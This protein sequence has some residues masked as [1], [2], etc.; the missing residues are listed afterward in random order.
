MKHLAIV[1]AGG[2]GSRM[3][4]SVPK[5]FLLLDGLPVLMHTLK[6]F[7]SSDLQPE[8]FLV[9]AANE[10]E[11]W[12]SLC[13]DHSFTIPHALITGG[14]NRFESVQN[15]LEHISMRST[16]SVPELLAGIH[17]GV[18]PLISNELISRLYAQ[19]AIQGTAIPCVEPR[20]SVRKLIGERSEVVDRAAF[21][22]MQT[23]QCFRYTQLLE[24]YRRAAHSEF[25]DDAAVVEAAGTEV[26][27]VQGEYRNLKITYPEDL[28]MAEALLSENSH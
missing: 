26:H 21:R 11:A 27:L 18:R 24:A 4:A 12:K 16:S 20:E 5:Q 3:K 19:A 9:L 7:A 22:L 6:A 10:Q 2:N 23:P 15:A 13:H 17:D 14:R 25:T 8:L 28:R 1:L